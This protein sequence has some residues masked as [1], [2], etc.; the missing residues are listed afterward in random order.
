MKK[1]KEKYVRTLN[2]KKKNKT[3]TFSFFSFL[4][5]V[6]GELLLDFIFGP[7]RPGRSFPFPDECLDALP[8]M[9]SPCPGMGPAFLGCTGQARAARGTLRVWRDFKGLREKMGTYMQSPR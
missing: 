6:L 7:K 4:K 9:L 1:N 2:Q 3:V 5:K 8:K